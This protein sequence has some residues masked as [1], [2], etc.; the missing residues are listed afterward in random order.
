MAVYG[1]SIRANYRNALAATYPTSRRIAGTSFFHGAVDAYAVAHPSRSGDLNEY[2][3]AFGTFLARYPP[4]AELPYLPDVA[5]LEWAIDEAT[6][7]ADSRFNPD[8]VLDALARQTANALP[9]LRLAIEPSCRFVSSAFPLLRIWQVNQPDYTGDLRVDFTS[10]PDS[11]RV[12]RE[13]EVDGPEGSSSGG[14]AIERLDAGDFRWLS[15]LEEGV[16][17]AEAI[18]RAR[19]ADAAFDLQAALHRFIGDGSLAGIQSITSE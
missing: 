13:P 6:R 12:R 14:V 4:A 1:R 5:R 15:T 2:G 10:G 8:A 18:E 9:G 7:A 16:T 17:L 3:D 19:N 11:L